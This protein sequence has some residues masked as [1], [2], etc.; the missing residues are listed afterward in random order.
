M[1]KSSLV[2]RHALPADVP[3]INDIYNYYVRTSTVTF[4]A[5]ETSED[6]RAEWL[7]SHGDAHPVMVVERDGVVVGWGSV[8]PWVT[9]EGWCHT[10]ELSVYV[11]DGETKGGAGSTVLNG[12]IEES[13]RVGHHVLLAQIVVDNEPC[14]RMVERAG[15]ERVGTFREVGRK[16]DRWLD[17]AIMGRVLVPAEPL[18]KEPLHKEPEKPPCKKPFH[19][20]NIAKLEK[21]N[22]PGRFETLIP[23]VMWE[24]LGSPAPKT[25]VEIGAGTG[26]FSAAFAAMAP[27]STVLAADIEP[28]MIEWMS[29]NRPEVAEGVLLPVLSEETRVPLGDKVADLVVMI[30]LHHEL[31]DPAISYADARRLLRPGGRLLVVDWADRG[32]PK[33]PPLAIRTPAV[34]V[35][36]ILEGV[37]FLS[38]REHEDLP[39][40]WLITAEEPGGTG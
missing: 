18:C 28:K 9:S 12:L 2:V 4:K 23:D 6:W 26:L 5:T 3:V 25:I 14:L 8:T 13:I 29:S 21:L 33:G 30:N 7:A 10:G 17:L 35:I 24:A 34:Q 19:K 22:D 36:S 37:G 38:V 40:H 1:S 16:F 11:Q 20:F 27:G 15:F 39:W 31:K 32:T